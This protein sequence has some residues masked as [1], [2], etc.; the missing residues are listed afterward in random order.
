MFIKSIIKDL[1]YFFCQL[2]LPYPKNRAIILMYHSIGQEGEFFQT[3]PANFA[4]QMAY[5]AD[6]NFKVISLADCL[7][8][9]QSGGNFLKKTVVITFDDGYLDNYNEAYPILQRYNFPA[10]IFVNTADLGGFRVAR[11]GSKLALLSEKEILAMNQSGL[12]DFGSHCHHHQKL[13]QLAI[14]KA[15]EE[16]S[17]S[18]IILEKLL[19]KKVSVLAYPTG[20][21]NEQVKKSAGKFYKTALTVKPGLVKHGV[22]LLEM[23]RNAVDRPV[24]MIQFK[25]IVKYGKI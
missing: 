12:I 16:L 14:A 20:R 2:V 21:Y 19:S 25:G 6:N 7:D 23:P 13:H 17:E 8:I 15:E 9:L 18:Q 24:S 3:T 11:G 5:L 22:D 4:Q 10:T 1:I